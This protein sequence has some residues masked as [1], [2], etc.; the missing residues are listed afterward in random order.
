LKIARFLHDENEKYGVLTGEVIVALPALAERLGIDLPPNL[1]ELIKSGNGG[2][3]IAESVMAKATGADLKFCSFDMNHVSFLAPVEFPPKILLLGLNYVDHVSEAKEKVPD[4]P[5]IFMKPHT[6]II[7][8]GQNIIKP[9]FVTQLD[10][11]GELAVVIGKRVKDV[12][13]QE[14]ESCIFGYTVLNDVSARNFQFKDGQWTRGKSFDT[15]APIGPWITTRS[16]LLDTS[17]LRIRTW[18][19]S[20][21]RQNATTKSMNF[22]VAQIIHHISRVM[23]LEPCDVIATGTPSGVGF[24]M[25]PPSYLKDGDVVRIE[26]EGI[27]VLEN[28]VIEK[29]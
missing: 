24:A 6:A 22:N 10:Y 18:V 26:I 25:K 7:G 1:E 21:L 13:V 12:S 23:T 16:Q 8:P 15:F 4:E 29:G 3:E 9:S 28:K 2:L 14:A 27:G 19:N 17:N 20:D 5:I 11:E